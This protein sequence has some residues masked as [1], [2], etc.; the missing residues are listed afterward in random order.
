MDRIVKR[1]TNEPAAL[2]GAVLFG[3]RLA[4]AD[5]DL[6]EAAAV[7]DQLTGMSNTLLGLVAVR[8]S[9]DGPQTRRSKDRER[10]QDRRAVDEL[11]H[12]QLDRHQDEEGE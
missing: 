4:G 5:V 6:A 10:E 3:L 7:A 11:V 8:Q 2:V 9:V 12:P 1:V